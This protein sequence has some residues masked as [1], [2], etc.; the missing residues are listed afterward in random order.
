MNALQTLGGNYIGSKGARSLAAALEN[1]A[2]LT[3][4]LDY[5]VIGAKGARHRRSRRARTSGGPTEQ[6]DAQEPSPCEQQHR[7][8]RRALARGGPREQQDAPGPGGPLQNN[9]ERARS[10]LALERRE[11]ALLGGDARAVEVARGRGGKSRAGRRDSLRG[12]RD[13]R[14]QRRDAGARLGDCG[15]AARQSRSRG[16]C[17]GARLPVR[18]LAWASSALP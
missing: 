10:T 11:R 14:A 7:R 8:S 17:A 1:N 13:A 9:G 15:V 2:T 18:Q 3:L 12:S 16:W 4:D 5:N 6:R